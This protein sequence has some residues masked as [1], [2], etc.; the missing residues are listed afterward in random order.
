MDCRKMANGLLRRGVLAVGGTCLGVLLLLV[1]AG[2]Q[3][4]RIDL[5]EFLQMQREMA[6]APTTRPSVKVAM[7]KAEI[8]KSLSPFTVGP[9][10]V[11]SVTVMGV[12]P[13]QGATLQARVR[14]DGTIELPLAGVIEVAKL[15]LED[16]EKAIKKKYEADVYQTAT[17]HVEV[18]SAE[19]TDVLVT[20]AVTTPGLVRLPRH[21]RNL[22]HAIVAAGG[23]SSLASGEATLCRIRDRE[24]K[25]T[26]DIR[27][28]ES[29]TEALALASL[30]DGDMITVEAAKPNMVFV[31]GLVNGPS[32]Q[33]YAPGVRITALQALAAAG[34][35]RTDV[36]PREAT[37]IR[38]M[39]T[40]EDVQVK[41]DLNRIMTGADPNIELAGGDIFWVPHTVETRIQEWISR[42]IHIGAGVNA[43]LRYNFIH[44]KDIFTGRDGGDTGV[45]INSN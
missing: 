35:L 22:L 18:A 43:G 37:L 19:T 12:D 16:V 14:R 41:L 27:D 26:F 42:N 32:P 21:E 45:L 33:S 3:E 7:G 40:G 6:P 28:A 1:V 30:E 13:G 20:G 31:G 36:L 10:D 17:V 24:K 34:G 25:M 5:D 38:R 8:D 4:H 23:V 2:C 29:V 39:P 9:S 44:T 11:L 15:E